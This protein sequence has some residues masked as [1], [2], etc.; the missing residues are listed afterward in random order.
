MSCNIRTPGLKAASA[1][2]ETPKELSWEGDIPD[3]GS[4]WDGGSSSDGR[5]H[6]VGLG[7]AAA[8]RVSAGVVGGAAN[9]AVA[10]GEIGGFGR[11]R[12][13]FKE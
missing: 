7:G 6:E 4:P 5:G 8:G 13:S 12:P 10:I 11:L 3:R 2:V 1:P 9:G